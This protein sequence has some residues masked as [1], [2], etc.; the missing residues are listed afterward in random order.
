MQR[1]AADGFAMTVRFAQ[2]RRQP[3]GREKRV[4]Q[5]ANNKF[6]DCPSGT[7]SGFAHA[8]WAFSR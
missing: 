7:A 3:V 2:K 1:I 6:I 5:C 4:S 8:E